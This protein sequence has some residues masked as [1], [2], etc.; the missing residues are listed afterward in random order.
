[1]LE[2]RVLGPLVGRRKLG[3]SP[4]GY[5]KMFGLMYAV[6]RPKVSKNP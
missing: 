3:L 2:T 6:F 1:M 5:I 4:L